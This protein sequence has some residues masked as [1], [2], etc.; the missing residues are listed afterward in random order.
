MAD[1]YNPLVS[2][3]EPLNEV[4]YAARDYPSIFDALLRRLKVLYED[5]Y[6]DY[7][8][9]SQ[10]MM[11]LELVAYAYSQLQWHL[12]RTAS[13]CFLDTARTRAAV[14]RLVKQIGYKMGAA[15][16][17]S[18]TLVLTFDDGTPGP[19]TMPARWKFAGPDSLTFESYSAVVQPSALA[20]GATINVDVR[21]GLTRLVSYT[22][23]GTK[24]QQYRL[25]NVNDT[26]FL[27]D[28]LVEVW[29]DGSL[30]T[31]NEFLEFEKTNQYEVG[32]NDDPPTIQF[33]DGIAGNIPPVGADIKI[34][35]VTINGAGGVCKAN[36]ITSSLDT[37]TIG[38]ELVNFTVTNPLGATGGLDAETADGAKRIAPFVFAAR[39]AA[40]TE[41]DYEGLS[42]SFRDPTYGSVALSYAHNP[43]G[44]YSDVV[45]NEYIDDIQ[46][47]LDSYLNGGVS[48]DGSV[49]FT[50]MIALEAVINATVTDL[51]APITGIGDDLT[52]L[53]TLRGTLESQIDAAIIG[54]ESARSDNRSIASSAVQAINACDNATT[55]NENL[56]A[57]VATLTSLSPSEATTILGYAGD[58]RGAVALAKTQSQSSQASA[59]SA[60][61]SLDSAINSQLNP[62]YES[63]HDTA[64]P[65]AFSLPSIIADATADLATIEA[66]VEGTGGLQDQIAAIVGEAQALEALVLPVLSLMQT[67]IGELFTDDCMSNYVQVLILGLDADGGYSAPSVG[68]VAG[69]QNRLDE[70]KEVTQQVEVVDGSSMLVGAEILAVLD[71]NKDA[72]VESEVVSDVVAVII[73]LLKGRQFNQPLYLSDLYDAV[74]AA[75]DGIRHVNISITGPV[76]APTIIDSDG[77]LV[78]SSNSVIKLGKLIVKD[79]AG[80]TLR[81]TSA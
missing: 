2:D 26:E 13:D 64:V 3:L 15:S 29:V 55:S 31:E 50:G 10:G 71:V 81:D 45:F 79:V 36:S 76:L 25:T 49:T 58:T 80:N 4:K 20:P 11:F 51:S 46:T 72:Y 60:S 62:A 44:A 37:L 47:D 67:R 34:R 1:P 63:V 59:A 74:E 73:S 53:E 70:I 56:I 21:E 24:N 40:I 61:A 28:G 65:P 16:A 27:G 57:Y 30:W 8:T 54:C 32:Y 7:A 41:P 12:D 5:V 14:A 38:G 42:E 9:T 17:S 23:D 52:N 18:T 33:G 48:H 39:G 35:Y 68:L 78:P 75:S 43:R 69:L 66:L 77:N 6:N 19:F 22:G